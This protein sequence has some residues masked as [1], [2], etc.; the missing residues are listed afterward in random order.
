M[1]MLILTLAL[2]FTS[3]SFVHQPTHTLERRQLPP[4]PKATPLTDPYN[5]GAIAASEYT[6]RDNQALYISGGE[7]ASTNKNVAYRQAFYKLDL[8]VPWNASQAS[9]TRLTLDY[10]VYGPNVK[11]KIVLSRD[12]GALYANSND[13]YIQGYITKTNK[14]QRPRP[15]NSVPGNFQMGSIMD[16]DSGV[17]Y[18]LGVCYSS[19]LD[20]TPKCILS[21]FDTSNGK[22]GVDYVPWESAKNAVYQSIEG[23]YSQT[24]KSLFFLQGTGATISTVQGKIA[25]MEY[26]TSSKSWSKLEAT[27]DVPDARIGSCF[28]AANGG[29]KLILAGGGKPPQAV[30]GRAPADTN[31]ALKEVYVLDVATATWSKLLDA[32]SP[33]YKP[34]CA[35]SADSLILYGGYSAHAGNVANGTIVTNGGNPSI[36][37]LKENVWVT[38]YKPSSSVSSASRASGAISFLSSAVLVTSAMMSVGLQSPTS[39]PN[40]KSPGPIA[41]SFQTVRENDVLYIYSG[42]MLSTGSEIAS[43]KNLFYRLHLSI[44]GIPPTR[45][46]SSG[47]LRV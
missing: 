15:L 16:L 21:T 38:A 25:I 39:P 36:L 29:A 45:S 40:D 33:Y 34:V 14:W 11:A 1:K 3:S 37:D 4:P 47:H 30:N 12:G 23:V 27:G 32:P 18:N 7:Y 9:W 28:V 13:Y 41:G 17:A 42:E 43:K 22:L 46:D 24:Q 5:P 35:V 19:S 2:T 6:F 44:P 8:S 31:V 26:K 20:V 10:P